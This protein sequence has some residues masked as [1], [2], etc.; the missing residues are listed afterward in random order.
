M[1]SNKSARKSMPRQLRVTNRKNVDFTQLHRE[2]FIEEKPIVLNEIAKQKVI[3]FVYKG[4]ERFV[5]VVHPNWENKLHALDLKMLPRRPL[6]QVINAPSALSEIQ[7]YDLY[8][9]RNEVMEW[10]A[11][12]TYERGLLTGLH[13][14]TYNAMLQPT[15]KGEEDIEQ[16]EPIREIEEKTGKEF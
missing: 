11:Y 5:L 16:P 14:V 2:F 12:R 3:R 4:K 9:R 8:V 15:E 6:L 10:D 7:L 13:E 1:T